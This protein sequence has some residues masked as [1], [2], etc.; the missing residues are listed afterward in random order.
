MA[1][2]PE[3]PAEVMR[4][5]IEAIRKINNDESIELLLV[6]VKEGQ[7]PNMMSTLPPCYVNQLLEWLVDNQ[8]TSILSIEAIPTKQ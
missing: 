5:V 3:V 7:S 4:S 2:A 6:A 1:D 8:A